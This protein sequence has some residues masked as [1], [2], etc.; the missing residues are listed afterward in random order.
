MGF[1]KRRANSKSKMLLCNFQ[2]IE[3]QILIDVNSVVK[4]EDI[5]E[6]MIINWDQIAMKLVPSASWTME[7]R[8]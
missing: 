1:S 4:M 5:P 7:N 8:N 3:E 6:D 2:A